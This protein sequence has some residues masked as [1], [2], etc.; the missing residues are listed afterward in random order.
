MSPHGCSTASG[1]S[2]LGGC[3]G[4]GSLWG[5]P[6]YPCA[7][8]AWS[9]HL[10]IVRNDRLHGMAD[11]RLDR[12]AVASKTASLLRRVGRAHR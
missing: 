2:L 12:S 5:S 10:N 8:L 1:V 6:C 7:V 9:L 4:W 3:A 11:A